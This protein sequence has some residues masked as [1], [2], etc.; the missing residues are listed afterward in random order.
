[1]AKTMLDIVTDIQHE[2][3]TTPQLDALARFTVVLLP[4]ILTSKVPVTVKLI[5]QTGVPFAYER[6]WVTDMAALA[7]SSIY[8]KRIDDFVTRV[9]TTYHLAYA[10]LFLELDA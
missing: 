9:A 1:M 6:T 5:P 2:L 7:N 4:D 10:Q 8:D 3:D